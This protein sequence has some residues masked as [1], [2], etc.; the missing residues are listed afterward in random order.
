M[1]MKP[2]VV[3]RELIKPASSSPQDLLQLSLAY[4][5]AGPAAYVSTIFFYKT[6]SGESLDITSGRLKTSLSDTLSRFYPLA[7]RMEGDKIICNDEGAVFTEASHRF[8]P[9]GF[10]QKQP[11]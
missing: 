3:G 2:E 6:V 9:L 4:V 11:R 10:P 8:S 1:E 5:S 7:G